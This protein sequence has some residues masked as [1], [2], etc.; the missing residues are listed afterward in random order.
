VDRPVD[1]SPVPAT[2]PPLLATGTGDRS[3]KP[4]ATPPGDRSTG[5]GGAV[6]AGL[7][8]RS[9]VTGSPVAGHGVTGRRSRGHRSP[10]AVAGIG[11]R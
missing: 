8:H 2:G 6:A 5:S 10:L 3:A 4:V 7:G 1:R 9:P 11:D